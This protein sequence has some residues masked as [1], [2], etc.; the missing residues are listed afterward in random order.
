MAIPDPRSLTYTSPFFDSDGDN[1]AQTIKT[2]SGLLHKLMVYNPNPNIAFVQFFDALAADVVVGTTVPDYV[3]FVPTGDGGV[4]DD[5][6]PGLRF[7]TGIT[8]ACTTTATGNGDPAT[9]LTLS[10]TYR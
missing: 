10:G 2:S 9:G 1:T 4:I 5:Y 3:L 8:Y 7:N 6:V